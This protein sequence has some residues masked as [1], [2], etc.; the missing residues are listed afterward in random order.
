MTLTRLNKRKAV[1]GGLNLGAA[2]AQPARG[3]RT[4]AAAATVDAS[5]ATVAPPPLAAPAFN[6]DAVVKE[7]TALTIEL[8]GEKGKPTPANAGTH[9][10]WI[11]QTV[12]KFGGTGKATSMPDTN[13]PSYLNELQN[14]TAAQRVANAVQSESLV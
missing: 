13:L 1:L 7:I 14:Y 2:S 10:A 6:R 5:A 8:V 9:T 3:S 11:K 4:K 12:A